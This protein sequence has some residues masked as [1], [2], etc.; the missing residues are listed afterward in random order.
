MFHQEQ[1][2]TCVFRTIVLAGAAVL[3]TTLIALSVS[4][5][6]SVPAT[7]VQAAKSPKFASKL[8][9]SAVRSGFRPARSRLRELK[10]SAGTIRAASGCVWYAGDG[11]HYGRLNQLD[12][13]IFPASGSLALDSS[14]NLY[15]TTYECGTNNAGT[16]WQFTP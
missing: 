16:A 9:H 7:A 3:G 13:Q 5:Q 11:W 10:H 1:R 15:G 2:V 14:G 6:T 4:A 8:A 12:H